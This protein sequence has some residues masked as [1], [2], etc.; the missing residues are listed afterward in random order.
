LLFPFRSCLSITFSFSRRGEVLTLNLNSKI[1]DC[2][3]RKKMEIKMGS[4][5]PQA[6]KGYGQVVELPQDPDKAL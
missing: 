4:L 6:F 5:T 1:V 3:G 2:S